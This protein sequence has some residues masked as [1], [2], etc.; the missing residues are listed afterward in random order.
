MDTV[1]S[2]S[3]G[4]SQA[5]MSHW[6]HHEG[7]M[8]LLLWLL[9][10]VRMGRQQRLTVPTLMRVAYGEERLQEAHLNLQERKRLVRTFESDLEILNHYGLRPEFDPLTYPPSLQPLWARLEAV[11]EDAEEALDFWIDDANNGGLL[12]AIGPRGKW[13]LLMQA[14]IQR[15]QLPP[16]WHS[17]AVQDTKS[18]ARSRRQR[19]A[20]SSPTSAV[21]AVSDPSFHP[22]K[23]GDL[24]PNKALRGADISAARR[25]KGISQ[26]EL[27]QRLGRSQSW[28]RDVENERFQIGS[29]DRKRLLKALHPDPGQHQ[30]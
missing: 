25:Q 11:P 19:K 2:E 27:A 10:K 22:A 4:V 30:A 29:N 24:S 12:T 16:D 6:Q 8:R 17:Q 14:R 15:F 26:R 20:K 28:V 3:A 5:V 18:S 13:G 1:L 7:A 23:T 9:F 21:A